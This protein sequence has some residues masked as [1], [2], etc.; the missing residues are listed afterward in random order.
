MA[1]DTGKKWERGGGEEGR[2]GQRCP[3]KISMTFHLWTAQQYDFSLQNV[4]SPSLQ[5]KLDKNAEVCNNNKH[6]GASL[7]T[8]NRQ[9]RQKLVN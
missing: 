9:N 7:Y 3:P 5:E 1:N 8:R 4:N 6:E 2:R